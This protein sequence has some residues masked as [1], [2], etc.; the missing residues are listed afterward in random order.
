[1]DEKLLFSEDGASTDIT[2]QLLPNLSS[3]ITDMLAPFLWL[4]VGLS[5]IFIALYISS[6]LRRRKLEKAIFDIQKTVHEIDMRTKARSSPY[7]PSP[8]GIPPSSPD[9]IAA[10]PSDTSDNPNSQAV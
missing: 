8:P 4:S 10:K 1:M 2:T 7:T 3:S 6:I 9:L 5:I